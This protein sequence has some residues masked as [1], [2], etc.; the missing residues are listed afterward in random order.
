[1]EQSPDTFIWIR[2]SKQTDKRR[3]WFDL[4]RPGD[5]RPGPGPDS[6]TSSSV[7]SYESSSRSR[8]VDSGDEWPRS[9]GNPGSR[10]RSRRLPG[11]GFRGCGAD[12]LGRTRDSSP[13]P[14][15]VLHPS[16]V[17]TRFC[18]RLSLD[19]SPEISSACHAFGAAT[20][21]GKGAGTRSV[22]RRRGRV[23][24]AA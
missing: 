6:L 20:P 15:G 22:R 2:Q 17:G 16:G 14:A 23:Q 1:M 11:H 12:D 21:I 19:S 7:F 18:P 5:I 13:R 4:F 24:R 10:G 3:P 8:A 9:S